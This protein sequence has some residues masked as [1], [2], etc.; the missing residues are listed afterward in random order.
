MPANL[1]PI[2]TSCGPT[3]RR[4]IVVLVSGAVADVA[5]YA[6]TVLMSNRP[7]QFVEKA[8][9]AATLRHHGTTGCG[10]G[11][12]PTSA[13]WQVTGPRACTN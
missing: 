8:N 4:V 12:I 6:E 5:A 3:S 7:L 9:V 1:I 13:N 2:V 10:A 11:V